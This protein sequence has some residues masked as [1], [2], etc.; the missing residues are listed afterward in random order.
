MIPIKHLNIVC[1]ISY[2]V[3]RM[4]YVVCRV[5]ETEG[6]VEEIKALGNQII[7][8]WPEGLIRRWGGAATVQ[9]DYLCDLGALCG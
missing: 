6:G 5:L 7:R 9:N 3:S 8:A 4:S 2:I 1:R